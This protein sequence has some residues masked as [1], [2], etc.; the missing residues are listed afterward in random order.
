MTIRE[1]EYADTDKLA[2][3][4]LQAAA[5]QQLLDPQ[6]YGLVDD[7]K[8]NYRRW[9][10]KM[11]EDPRMTV[12]VAEEEAEVVAFLIASVE[13]DPPIY[14]V[15][16]FGVIH[17]IWVNEAFRNRRV[18]ASLVKAL[19]QKFEAMGIK[20]IRVEAITGDSVVHHLFESCGF[21]PC[22]SLMLYEKSAPKRRKKSAN[23]NSQQR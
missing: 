17:D 3:M 1:A 7:L 21:R 14:K 16:E 13:K 12:L 9:F 8:T 6:R 10:G 23:A 18:G 20:Q 11:A 4:I 19:Q 5:H 22:T 15:G 2:P